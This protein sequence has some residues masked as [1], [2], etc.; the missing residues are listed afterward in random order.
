MVDSHAP[1]P[2]DKY[3]VG[4]VIAAKYRLERLLGEGGQAWV[5]QARNLA[6]DASVAIKVL[7]GGPSGAP[8][9]K[10]LLQEARAAAS[11]GHPAIVRVFDLGEA[12]SGDPF[13]VMELL[14]GESLADRLVERGRLSAV[15][16]I[17]VLLPIADALGAAHA[18]GIVHRDLKPDNVFLSL[19][20]DALQPKLLDFGIVKVQQTASD[21]Q[22]LSTLT[23][24]VVGS[25]AYL[26]PEQARGSSDIDQRVDVW[27]LCVTLYECL[28]D[29]VPFHGDNYNALLRSIVED[30]PQ[31]IL[32]H[33]V[34]EPSLWQILKRGLAKSRDERWPSTVDLGRALALWASERGVVDDVC[35]TPLQSKWLGSQGTAASA[36]LVQSSTKRGLLPLLGA[37][38]LLSAL[39]LFGLFWSSSQT[40][41]ARGADPTVPKRS[42]EAQRVAAAPL[43]S[44]PMHSAPLP[45]SSAPP[46]ATSLT[47]GGNAAL[48]VVPGASANGARSARPAVDSTS[49]KPLAPRA[50]ASGDLYLISP[51]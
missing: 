27:G 25:P 17:R 48:S 1:V 23:G 44:E 35:R 50:K 3:A 30:E 19:H 36:A 38:A 49:R 46:E 10:R 6:L 18:K 37:A 28:T 51:Y 29:A 41:A 43:V 39:L 22:Q 21:W 5:W 47:A 7:R 45:G 13:L 33:G 24:S 9:S 20:G 2:P 8:Q 15:D 16:A 32:D 11:L 40:P 31:S 34:D 26:S 4:D 42:A 12:S 14:T